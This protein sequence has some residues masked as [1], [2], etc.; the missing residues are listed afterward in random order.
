MQIIWD[1]NVH[2]PDPH[3]VVSQLGIAHSQGCQAGSMR[4]KLSGLVAAAIK[5][6]TFVSPPSYCARSAKDGMLM[7]ICFINPH[8]SE[9]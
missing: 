3:N 7:L 4:H 2:R 6:L 1:V 8:C 9:S 5:V